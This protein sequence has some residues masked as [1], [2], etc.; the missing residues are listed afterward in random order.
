MKLIFLQ[1]LPTLNGALFL[2]VP[3][4]KTPIRHTAK[5]LA[6]KMESIRRISTIISRNE[7]SYFTRRFTIITIIY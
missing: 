6:M 2:T 4:S 3:T 5:S 1:E 7:I